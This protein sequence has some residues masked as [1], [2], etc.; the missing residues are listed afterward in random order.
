MMT[1]ITR[2]SWFDTAADLSDS[3]LLQQVKES[4]E[5]FHG[6]LEVA[7]PMSDEFIA[8]PLTRCWLGYETA[9]GTYAAIMSVEA[10]RRGFHG[11]SP[12]DIDVKMAIYRRRMDTSLVLPPWKDDTD[13]LRSHRSNLMRRFPSQ[14]S[15]QKTPERMPYLWPFVDD[16]GGYGLFIS[17]HDRELLAAGE[18]Q[19][20][21]EI[22]KRIENL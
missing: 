17:R 16:E 8:H 7:E 14:Y 6:L 12:M 10:V 20:P 5:F 9:A 2:I 19:L 1:W 13:V 18:R 11:R 3:L 21:N 22:K 15:W 4:V